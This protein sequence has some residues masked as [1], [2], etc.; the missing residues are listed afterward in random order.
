MKKCASCE[1]MIG[2]QAKWCPR[3]GAKV[4]KPVRAFLW[5]TLFL[6]YLVAKSCGLLE[7]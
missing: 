1:W 7:Q 2:R 4:D 5:L 6:L 3:C